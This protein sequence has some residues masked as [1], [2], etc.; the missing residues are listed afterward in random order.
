MQEWRHC[1]ERGRARL[2]G[3]GAGQGVWRN[4]KGRLPWVCSP[5]GKPAWKWKA[6]DADSPPWVIMDLL[7]S[8]GRPGCVWP[9]AGW[10]EGALLGKV[11]R[12]PIDRRMDVDTCRLLVRWSMSLL[13]LVLSCRWRS[14]VSGIR[15]LCVLRPGANAAEVWG[16]EPGA[17]GMGAWVAI[18]AARWGESACARLSTV[19]PPAGLKA[20][21]P[22]FR[23]QPE[24]T[25]TLR[26]FHAVRS[27]CASAL[28]G[29][30]SMSVAGR[31]SSPREA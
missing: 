20:A 22:V 1:T 23:P 5:F 26:R 24:G 15:G 19:L 2:R 18:L 9:G 29:R 17:C 3:S 12:G 4:K 21:R 13:V 27:C 28:T 30:V 25:A 11:L 16:R 6:H 14:F 10:P 31:G 8:S 7:A